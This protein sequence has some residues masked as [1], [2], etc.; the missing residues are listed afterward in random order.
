MIKSAKIIALI[1]ILSGIFPELLSSQAVQLSSAA[2]SA[3]SAQGTL[4]T[5]ITDMFAG[6]EFT[7]IQQTTQIRQES[8][9]KKRKGDDKNNEL[10]KRPGKQSKTDED[11]IDLT[12]DDEQP[13][14]TAA[15]AQQT[16]PSGLPTAPAQLPISNQV[17]T[18]LPLL[19]P[20]STLPWSTLPPSPFSSAF[21]GLFSNPPSSSS[22]SS[23]SSSLNSPTTFATTA[24]SLTPT[25]NV[26]PYSAPTATNP[27]QY[28]GLPQPTL[29]QSYTPSPTIS[30]LQLPLGTLSMALATPSPRPSLS[31]AAA[32]LS[33]TAPITS[34]SSSSAG[35]GLSLT[36]A[37]QQQSTSAALERFA[38]ELFQKSLAHL[39]AI[40][41]IAFHQALAN[42]YRQ[43]SAKIEYELG[44][45][46]EQGRYGQQDMPKALTHF[47]RAA[48]QG[49]AGAQCKLGMFYEEGLSAGKTTLVETN[50]QQAVIWH[51]KAYAQNQPSAYEA[52][53]RCVE[54][55]K[56]LQMDIASTI[57]I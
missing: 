33:A 45:A 43:A 8:G 18:P 19:P 15:Q 54:R 51:K 30:P 27:S 41:N 6:T 40:D 39:Q 38:Q 16:S 56:K 21:S 35:S 25:T 31:I 53:K 26:F 9:T 4:F 24:V 1:L 14:Q 32:V 7:Q 5:A 23:S 28:L 12:G 55:I 10:N 29:P 22:S 57:K 36:T 48:E 2:S 3:D 49:H 47:T 46:Y 44:Q 13:T 52:L 42:N 20:F 11:V 17:L 34:S 37:V 50:I